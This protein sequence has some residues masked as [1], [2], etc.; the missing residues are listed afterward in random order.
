MASVPSRSGERLGLAASS[1][2]CGPPFFLPTLGIASGGPFAAA[3]GSSG[4]P[5]HGQRKKRD[6]LSSL[7]DVRIIPPPWGRK[8]RGRLERQ[9]ERRLEQ[10]PDPGEELGAVGAVEDAVIAGQ[11]DAHQLARLDLPRARDDRLRLELAD[12]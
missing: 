4:W 7:C 5:P 1:F 12:G 3:P 9:P 6:H 8:Q 10:L 2:I 11:G